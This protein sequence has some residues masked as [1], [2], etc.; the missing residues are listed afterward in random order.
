MIYIVVLISVVIIIVIVVV[1]IFTQQ[2]YWN[3]CVEI[4][5]ETKEGGGTKK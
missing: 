1:L 3:P 4:N 2:K 5:N